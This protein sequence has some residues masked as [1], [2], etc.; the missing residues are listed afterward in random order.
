MKPRQC[1]IDG[2]WVD[3]VGGRH[4]A[5]FDRYVPGFG[6]I[7]YFGQDVTVNVEH[8]VLRF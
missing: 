5:H 8:V 6:A 3:A 7:V 1:L 4:T 2:Q